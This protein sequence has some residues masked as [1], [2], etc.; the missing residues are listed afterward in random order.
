VVAYFDLGYGALYWQDP[1]DTPGGFLGSTGVGV[2]LDML[3]FT[4]LHAYAHFPVIGDRI[5]GAPIVLDLAIRA[6]F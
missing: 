2:F 6:H 4:Y 1:A 5:D 3:D